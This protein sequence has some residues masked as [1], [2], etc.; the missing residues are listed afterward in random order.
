MGSR[1]LSL[2]TGIF[3]LHFFRNLTAA[4]PLPSIEELSDL[5]CPADG[6]LNMVVQVKRT[7][8]RAKL[9]QA[10]KEFALVIRMIQDRDETP[11]L[12]SLRLQVA[13][14]KREA[15]V[16]WPWPAE[17]A[18]A[19]EIL[20]ML[21]EVE[22]HQ[23]DPFIVE[24]AD[25][26]EDLWALLWSQ[27]VRDP[28]A[29]IRYAAGRLIESF[30]RPDLVSAVHHDLVSSF[31]NAPRR[32]EG[33]RTGF[34][35]LA[36]DVTPGSDAESSRKIV[37]G[38]GFGFTELRQGCFRNRPLIFADL[39]TD[40][41]RWLSESE[42][43]IDEREM[44]VFWIDGRS[45]EGKSV[46]LRQL[47]AHLLLRYPDRVPVLEVN[48]EDVPQAVKERRE[49]LDRPALLVTDDLYAIR[50]RESWDEQL[51][52]VIETDLPP[53]YVLTCGP[54][55]QREEFERRF[56]EPFR[57][58]RFTVPQFKETERQEFVD[59]FIRR[60]G[61]SPDQRTLTTE[62]ALLVQLIFELYEGITLAEFARRFRKR[63]ELRWR[64]PRSQPSSRLSALLFGDTPWFAGPN[65]GARC[66]R[67][68]YH[69][70]TSATS[71]WLLSPSTS[72]THT[73]LGRFCVRSSKNRIRVSMGDRMGSGIVSRAGGAPGPFASVHP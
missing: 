17:A 13:C 34:L 11:L 61:K 44:P 26:L 52:Q 50:N 7:L 70:T 30:G 8:T 14:G 28:Q 3:L 10:L 49:A 72:R 12:H 38:G 62:N 31:A 29:I 2:Q 35:L 1:R 51:S 19:D 4:R 66:Y 63:L 24:Q 40:F 42:S 60:V 22:A 67:A 46:L 55:E 21:G 16:Q 23:A 68:G 71:G 33:P 43:H 59:W 36:E 25:P 27:G 56:A 65:R 53:V 5:V 48:R 6:Q 18:L 37:V 64:A 20:S 47:V 41:T 9:V 73:L 45:G 57:V 39:W 32:T 58:T 15:N 69:R 54:T